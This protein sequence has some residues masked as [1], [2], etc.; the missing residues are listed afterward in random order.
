MQGARVTGGARGDLR[1]TK[2]RR[3]FTRDLKWVIMG[4]VGA[5]EF[6]FDF[7]L[8]PY[9][10]T[11]TGWEEVVERFLGV[12]EAAA[13]CTVIW[14]VF[15]QIERLEARLEERNGELVQ[16]HAAA[17][18][19]DMQLEALHAASLTVAAAGSYV[20]VL[21]HIV[22]EAVRLT[23]ARYG[24]LAEFDEGENVVEFVTHGMDPDTGARVG[25][26][27][28]H[29]GLLKRLSGT[30]PVHMAD[31]T[32]DPLFS[33]FP[34][35]HPSFRTFLGVPIRWEGKLFGH[36]YLGGHDGERPF[37]D[38]EARLLEMFALQAAVAIARARYAREQASLAR[39]SERQEIAMQL[40]DGAL[41]SLYAVGLRLDRMRQRT[42]DSSQPPPV[43]LA[44]AAI[45]TAMDSIRTVL[46]T[47]DHAAHRSVSEEIRISV[48][49]L[50]VM[51]DIAV[52]W[53]GLPLADELPGAWA[54]DL[55][56]FVGEAVSNAA[57]HGRATQVQVAFSRAQGHV[58]L[59]VS[60]NGCGLGDGIEDTTGRGLTNL[61]RRAQRLGAALRLRPALPCGL[62]IEVQLPD[63]GAGEPTR[64]PVASAEPG[65]QPPA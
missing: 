49:T 24:A 21:R 3:R 37:A 26:A 46:N 52:V 65:P 47:L 13:M 14:I 2:A 42:P 29:R 34:A 38:D 60:D 63:P 11:H 51:C 31:V 53:Q 45:R 16:M 35:G 43:D 58:R 48:S 20:G 9:L 18:R 6:G 25:H 30:R 59:C 56:L 19:W 8:E 12:A 57:R 33:G 4:A 7:A 15:S 41:Q 22:R 27:P 55:G 39:L 10:R 28:T 23:R 36:L 5:V 61:E 54:R 40:H 44:L 64:L 50:A 1:E 32:R 62:L 17:T